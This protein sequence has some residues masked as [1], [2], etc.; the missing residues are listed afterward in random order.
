MK[1][2]KEIQLEIRVAFVSARDNEKII[3]E[4]DLEEIIFPII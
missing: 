4:I 1:T 2:L 3:G